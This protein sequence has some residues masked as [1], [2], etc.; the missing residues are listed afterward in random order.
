[1]LPSTGETLQAQMEEGESTSEIIKAREEF[2]ISMSRGGLLKP[3][4]ILY[5]TFIHASG[6]FK[7]LREMYF[8]RYS[9]RNLLK[10]TIQLAFL[11]TNVKTAITS[12][13]LLK[14]SP[15]LCLI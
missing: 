15:C 9:S 5:M 13:V 8:R 3:T 12:R 11:M 10:R 6:L 1:M 14:R 7:L 4:D 2:L